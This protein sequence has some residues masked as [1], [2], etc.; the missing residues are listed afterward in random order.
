VK[1]GD[2]TDAEEKVEKARK[3]WGVFVD[4]VGKGTRIQGTSLNQE[5]RLWI[6]VL[7]WESS[8]IRETVL[9]SAVVREAKKSLDALVWKT[10]VASFAQ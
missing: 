3:V 9:G 6:G 8:E 5:E 1:V 7:G 2:E 4:A 10:F